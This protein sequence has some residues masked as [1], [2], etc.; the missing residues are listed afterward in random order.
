MARKYFWC[1]TVS[2]AAA[3]TTLSRNSKQNVT[4]VDAGSL[5][6]DTTTIYSSGLWWE[7][8]SMCTLMLLLLH[9]GVAIALACARMHCQDLVELGAH[10]IS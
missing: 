10:Y 6:H 8:L 5:A 9:T 7:R 4:T 1:D 2:G 3:K